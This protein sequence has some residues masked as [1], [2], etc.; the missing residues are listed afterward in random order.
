MID[1]DKLKILR[2]RLE[3][4][5]DFAESLWR[6]ELGAWLHNIG[7][8]HEEF[9]AK[10]RPQ[11]NFRVPAG[12]LLALGADVKLSNN[13][14]CRRALKPLSENGV[15]LRIH[16]LKEMKVRF[17][18]LLPQ[19]WL[20]ETRIEL[21]YPLNDRS[22]LKNPTT[23]YRVADIIEFQTLGWYLTGCL[24]ELLGNN[25]SNLTFLLQAS[26]E[27]AS[28]V[29]KDD[30]D[31]DVPAAKNTPT[32]TF[33]SSVFGFEKAPLKADAYLDI[34]SNL[35]AGLEEREATF[36]K[37]SLFLDASVAFSRWFAD[38][39]LPVNDVTLLDISSAVAAFFKAS[40]AKSIL[41][42]GFPL[43]YSPDEED[44]NKEILKWR[45]LR[46]L[47]DGPAFYGRVARIP[48][49]LTRRDELQ[50]M[51]DRV[52]E[53]FETELWI[54]NEVYRDSHGACYLVPDLNGD[55]EDGNL[56]KALVSEKVIEA[57]KGCKGSEEISPRLCVTKA[58]SKG[59]TIGDALNWG[60]GPVIPDLAQAAQ[61]WKDH[62]HSVCPV[63]GIRPIGGGDGDRKKAFDRKVCVPCEERRQRRSVR[64][65][66]NPKRT[67]WVDE[68]ADRNG[69]VALV[70]GRFDLSSW[71]TED[72]R[73]IRTLRVDPI[74]KTDARKNPSFARLRRVWETTARFW[75]EVADA[76][77]VD[78]NG[79]RLRL[80]DL[81]FVGPKPGP[82][83][84]YYLRCDPVRLA[85]TYD[86]DRN[87]FLTAENLERLDLQQNG[88]EWRERLKGGPW[89]LEEPTGYG[90]PNKVNVQ[91]HIGRYPEAETAKFLPVIEID[92]DPGNMLLLVPAE[93]ALTVVAEIRDKYVQEMGKVRNRL[94]MHVGIVFGS[95]ATPFYSLLDA[96]R[97]LNHLPKGFKQDWTVKE[98]SEA[99][100]P[101]IT[102]SFEEGPCWVVPTVMGDGKEDKWYPYFQIR[103]K[104]DKHVTELKAGD[105]T[106]VY[107]S[108]FDF[109]YLDTAGGRFEIAYDGSGRRRSATNSRRV[110]KRPYFLD[111]LA[112]F[113]KVWTVLS[114]RAHRGQI[115]FLNGILTEKR[116]DWGDG[117]E[118]QGFVHSALRNLNWKKGMMPDGPLMA[119]LLGYAKRG[120][121]LDSL[122]IHL[123]VMKERDNVTQK[124]EEE[125]QVN[126]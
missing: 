9:S 123:K 49:L 93:D 37:R 20:C 29:E 85:V 40:M 15:P 2:G 38:K 54:A 91:V 126:A 47:V 19:D 101:S 60:P 11:Y 14:P 90:Q 61:V 96:A 55:D 21:P 65:L 110:T 105:R 30:E 88:R 24:G 31:Q 62:R 58:H 103:D 67:I 79:E 124:K 95:S 108:Y 16:E 56:L 71:L 64:W 34:W 22:N 76:P 86:A 66:N 81:R 52:T 70:T 36:E 48:D 115:E 119:E 122:E 74:G 4:M 94:A 27:R 50:K 17:A 84:S 46:V 68:V 7:K 125:E 75:E 99:A 12:R 97:R 69:R 3:G 98:R 10:E 121:L 112:A 87:C 114:K 41:D 23:G 28:N 32:S 25:S 72:G 1:E 42:G 109:E 113:D 116:A 77:G 33:V 83:Q 13:S 43:R 45:V 51:L 39:T 8:L 92:K 44:H 102:V 26:H 73:M 18:Q 57:W 107:P 111:D 106:T 118:W 59:L 104:K 35:G 63:C 80:Q 100:G 5:K 120:I 6:A 78:K 53:L 82:G 89:E 117:E